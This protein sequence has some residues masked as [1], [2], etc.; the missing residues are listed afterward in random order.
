MQF[1]LYVK[2]AKIH[3]RSTEAGESYK[4]IS[5]TEMEKVEVKACPPIAVRIGPLFRVLKGTSLTAIGV[6][7]NCIINLILLF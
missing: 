1:Y 2:A 5:A 3:V 7:S 6:I 4:M